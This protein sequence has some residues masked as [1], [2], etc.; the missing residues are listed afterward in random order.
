[1]IVHSALSLPHGFG[2]SALDRPIAAKAAEQR[3]LRYS[4]LFGP[5]LHSEGFTIVGH[6]M[7][8]SA[9]T[10]LF[11]ARGPAAIARLVVA[12]VVDSIQRMGRTWP[13]SHIIVKS[14]E[15]FVPPLANFDTASP[16]F[17]VLRICWCRATPEHACPT[18]IFWSAPLAMRQVGACAAAA[19]CL[20]ITRAQSRGMDG[21]FRTTIAPAQPIRRSAW[22][23]ANV[24]KNHPAAETP[25]CEVI[26]YRFG[27]GYNLRS[28]A[29]TSNANVMRG[30]SG[31]RRACQ[32]P[33]FYQN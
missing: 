10:L 3:D 27:N 5:L 28:H 7:I 29:R 26:S 32:S 12:I 19:A 14:L 1:M 2:Q 17:R 15:G 11:G 31:V 6:K 9:V 4:H 24:A 18:V 23:S 8:D 30:L 33:L 16:V 13:R 25:T 21:A 22:A 20:R